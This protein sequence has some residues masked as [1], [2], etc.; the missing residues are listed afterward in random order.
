MPYIFAKTTDGSYQQVAVYIAGSDG[1]RAIVSARDSN[2]SLF[3]GLKVRI[4]PE[5]KEN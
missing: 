5:Q 4:P 3:A 2:I 1:E